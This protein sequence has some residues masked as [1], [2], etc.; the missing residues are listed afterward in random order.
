MEKNVFS[1]VCKN[2]MIWHGQNFTNRTKS[3]VNGAILKKKVTD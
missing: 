1:N 2:S 3:P